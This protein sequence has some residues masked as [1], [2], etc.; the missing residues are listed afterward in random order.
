MWL[1]S[2]LYAYKKVFDHVISA[3]TWHSMN[4]FKHVFMV[5][6]FLRFIGKDL[7]DFNKRMQHLIFRKLSVELSCINIIQSFVQE[8]TNIIFLQESKY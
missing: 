3:K 5:T 1:W 6:W 4:L 8:T 7:R 2:S